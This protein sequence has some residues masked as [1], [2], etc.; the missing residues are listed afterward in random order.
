MVARSSKTIYTGMQVTLIAQE[1]RVRTMKSDCN[2]VCILIGLIYESGFQLGTA[3][4]NTEVPN[5]DFLVIL[6]HT[7]EDPEIYFCI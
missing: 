1:H 6:D 5:F 7:A 2:M 4:C 3:V